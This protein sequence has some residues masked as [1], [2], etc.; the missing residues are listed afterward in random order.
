MRGSLEGCPA[1]GAGIAGTLPQSK[2][3]AGRAG[4]GRR[5]RSG[6]VR[7]QSS[8]PQAPDADHGGGT[9]LAGTPG[10]ARRRDSDHAAA[11]QMV[12]GRGLPNARASVSRWSGEQ[13]AGRAASISR[14]S[15]GSASRWSAARDRVRPGSARRDRR[16][17]ASGDAG[18]RDQPRTSGGLHHRIR[19]ANSSERAV[20]IDRRRAWARRRNA[21]CRCGV[22]EHLRGH[23]RIDTIQ[24]AQ[25]GRARADGSRSVGTGRPRGDRLDRAGQR[26]QPCPDRALPGSLRGR[27]PGS[28]SAWVRALTVGGPA[29]PSPASSGVISPRAGST[30]GGV[31]DRPAPGVERRAP[32]PRRLSSGC[33]R[34]GRW[35]GRRGGPGR[36][37]ARWGRSSPCRVRR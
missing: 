16:R 26:P 37:G 21:C 2:R 30:P 20:A 29:R 22:L 9:S 28:S 23:R 36:R 3:H 27:F 25:A 24:H 19:A 12:A 14:R 5:R 10:E 4:P 13:S 1:P 6:H 32:Q 33:G 11:A 35:R 18:A 7:R 31:P 17:R 8:G 34:R 15:S